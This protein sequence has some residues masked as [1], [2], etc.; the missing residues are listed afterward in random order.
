MKYFKLQ[1]IYQGL[2]IDIGVSQIQQPSPDLTCHVHYGA[3]PHYLGHAKEW[4]G[5]QKVRGGQGPAT[6]VAWWR[7]I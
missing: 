3:A 2:N 1:C 5:L 7:W 4:G 6:V